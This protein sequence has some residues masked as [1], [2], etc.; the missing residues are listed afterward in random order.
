MPNMPNV[1]KI[2][3]VAG[4]LLSLTIIT[5]AQNEPFRNNLGCGYV[6]KR[7]R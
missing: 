3:I 5:A 6:L 2:T 7:C 1:P 4:A